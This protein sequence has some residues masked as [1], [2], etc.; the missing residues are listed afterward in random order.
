MVAYTG[1]ISQDN[2]FTDSGF[3]VTRT[4]AG[5]LLQIEASQ[6][7]TWHAA[8]GSPNCVDQCQRICIVRDDPE[9]Q[10]VP[11]QH[12]LQCIEDP[13]KNQQRLTPMQPMNTRE[14]QP[15]MEI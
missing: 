9:I 3:T 8:K 6:I 12:K 4:A 14:R 1:V 7:L 2:I 13:V 15:G 11:E 10:P 5:K